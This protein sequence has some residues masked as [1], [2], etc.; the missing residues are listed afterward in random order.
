MIAQKIARI[1]LDE[2]HVA[3][4]PFRQPRRCEQLIFARDLDADEIHV[5]TSL[6]GGHE[7]KTFAEADFDLH[8]AGVTKHGLPI[9]RAGP[10]CYVEQVRGQILHRETASSAHGHDSSLEAGWRLIA[11]PRMSPWKTMLFPTKPWTLK[12]LCR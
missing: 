12:I 11:T 7:K 1:G 2:A 3:E 10:V 8:R 4:L 9:E 6:R 5:R